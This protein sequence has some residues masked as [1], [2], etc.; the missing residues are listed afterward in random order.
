MQGH[1]TPLPPSI[2]TLTLTT[3]QIPGVGGVWGRERKETIKVKWRESKKIPQKYLVRNLSGSPYILYQRLFIIC[4][5]FW[6]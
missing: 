4:N 2:L 6:T 1:R 5:Y 3:V